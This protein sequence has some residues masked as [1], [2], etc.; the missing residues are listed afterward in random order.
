MQERCESCGRAL[1]SHHDHLFGTAGQTVLCVCAR[2]ALDAQSVPGGPYRLVPREVC[3]MADFQMSDSQW[4]ALMIPIGLAFFVRASSA[5]HVVARYPGPAGA[6]ES[7]L[8]LDA[9]Q[10][11]ERANPKLA[12]LKPD[13]EALLVYR[14]GQIRRSYRVPIDRCYALIGLIRRE[15]RGLSGGAAMWSAIEEFFAG[16]QRDAEPARTL[17]HA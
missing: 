1:D 2:C 12:A 3:S 17:H 11:V 13:V 15:W 10:A 16:L 6:V 9:W 7:L 14:V 5:G 4:E 8:R